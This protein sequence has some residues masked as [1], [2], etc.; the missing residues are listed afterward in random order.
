MPSDQEDDIDTVALKRLEDLQRQKMIDMFGFDPDSRDTAP[1]KKPKKRS[2]S[3]ASAPILSSKKSRNDSKVSPSSHVLD[4]K[5]LKKPLVS[6]QAAANQRREDDSNFFAG[7]FTYPSLRSD[8]R[9]P[10]SPPPPI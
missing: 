2:H 4:S 8:P 7:A 6:T 1:K 9:T 10:P 5:D 3:D